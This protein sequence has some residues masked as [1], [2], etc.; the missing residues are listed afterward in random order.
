MRTATLVIVAAVAAATAASPAVAAP[1]KPITKSYTANAPAPDPSNQAG[2]SYNV[3]AQNVPQ[4]FDKKEFV[5]PGVG[6]LKVELSGYTGDWDLLI[7]DAAGNEVTSSGGSDVGTPAAA[8]TEAATAKI[9]KAKAKYYIVA[10]NFA[11]GSTGNVK[12]TFTY[13]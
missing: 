6:K 11:G 7:M 10:C 8:A 1:K 13:A 9:K 5:A 4:S 12:Y 2:Q 3:C